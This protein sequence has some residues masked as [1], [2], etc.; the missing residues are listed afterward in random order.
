MREKLRAGTRSGRTRSA[1]STAR[2]A[3]PSTLNSQI[4]RPAIAFT[5]IEVLIALAIFTGMAVVLG[6][7]YLNVLNAYELAGRSAFADEDVRFARAALLAEADRDA[8]EKGGEFDGGNNRRVRWSSVIEQ[9]DT[10]DL[11]SVT[12]LCEVNSPEMKQ[13]QVTQEV[14]R[15]LRPTWS[16]AD[17][18]GKL[19]AKTRDRILK[20]TRERSSP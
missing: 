15:V 6:S 14:M 11:F 20:I 8:A 12:F 9:T 7:A 4:P 1:G 2:R 18:R 3:Q 19:K 16:K 10:P 17:E 13:P 5:L